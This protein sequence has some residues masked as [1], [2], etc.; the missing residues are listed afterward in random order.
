MPIGEWGRKLLAE[1]SCE[2]SCLC[3][4]FHSFTRR[5]LALV[6]LVRLQL[7]DATGVACRLTVTASSHGGCQNVCRRIVVIW[8]LLTRSMSE[9]DI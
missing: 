2:K 3:G 5:S 6:F 1:Q 7:P 4:L 8:A 9:L